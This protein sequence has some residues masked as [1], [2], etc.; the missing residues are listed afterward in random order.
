MSGVLYL[1]PSPIGSAPAA[2]LP[3]DVIAVAHRVKHFLVENAK[4]ARAFLKQLE[5]P[6]PMLQLSII[7]IGHAPHEAEIA[8]WLAPLQQDLDVAI[9]SE[10]GCPAIADPGATLVAA[11]HRNGWTVTPLV[12]PSAIVLALMASGLNGQQFRFVG[13]LPIATDERAAAIHS[14]ERASG[15]GETQIFIETPYRNVT[16]FDALLT[17]C[18]QTTR[19]AVAAGITTEEAFIEQR[20]IGQWRQGRPYVNARLIKRPAV[21]SLLAEPGQPIF[22]GSA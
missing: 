21:F 3:R 8:G 15:T 22:T 20:T 18:A 17:H 5:H 2:A 16:L 6:T 1:L 4:S 7:E 14:L 10:A 9:I 19:L 12:G 13:Y 11:A